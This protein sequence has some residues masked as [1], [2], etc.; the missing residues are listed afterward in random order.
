MAYVLAR[1]AAAP[2][3][4]SVFGF[5]V[6]FA[7][8]V[9]PGAAKAADI[10]IFLD[11]AKLVKLPEKAV[12][13]VVGNPLIADATIQPG[14]LMVITGKGYGK[15]NMIALD[16]GGKVLMR[17][18]VEV[19]GPRGDVVVVYRGIDRETYSCAPWCER[20]YTLGD[21]DDYFN[22]TGGQIATR[23]GMAQSTVPGAASK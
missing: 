1:A 23:N 5:A 7:L 2:L 15:T 16:R 18:S 20:R 9:L 6:G 8:G 11:Q 13:V 4:I 19:S 22:K 12:T 21:S 10:D 3:R 17:S 14:G